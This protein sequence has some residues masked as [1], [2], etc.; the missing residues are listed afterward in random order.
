MHKIRFL[1]KQF[2]ETLS[3]AQTE[4]MRN[5]VVTWIFLGIDVI[6]Q[7]CTAYS[8]LIAQL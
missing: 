2:N 6:T 7:F 4:F 8:A 3:G 5:F 1:F